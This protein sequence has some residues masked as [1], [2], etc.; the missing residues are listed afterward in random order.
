MRRLLKY[1]GYS[2]FFVIMLAL[3]L[4]LTFPA[5]QVR[6]YAERQ[7]SKQIGGTVRIAKLDLSLTGDITLEGIQIELPMP[8]EKQDSRRGPRGKTSGPGAAGEPA[9]PQDND[10]GAGENETHRENPPMFLLADKLQIDWNPLGIALGKPVNMVINGEIQNGTV[11]NLRIT[12]VEDGWH[13]RVD[14]IQGVNLTPTRLLKRFVGTDIWATLS[15]GKDLDFIWRG[16]VANS[17]GTIALKLTDTLIPHIVF[18]DPKRPSLWAEAFDVGVGDLTLRMTL[19]KHSKSSRRRTN[20]PVEDENRLAIDELKARGHHLLLNMDGGQKHTIRFQRP[21]TGMG[22]VDIKFVFSF[23]KEFFAWKGT[24]VRA[25]GSTVANATHIG[26]KYTL[27]GPQSP[28]ARGRVGKKQT[29]YRYG[30]HCTGM[31]RDLN[32]LPEKPS[33]AILPQMGTGAPI[34]GKRPS[35]GRPSNDNNAT[36]PFK[37]P[38]VRPSPTR[39]TATDRLRN[40]RAKTTGDKGKR[41]SRLV[42]PARP[43]NGVSTGRISR[44]PIPKGADPDLDDLDLVPL[45]PS[46]PSPGDRVL[47]PTAEESDDEE[48][49]EEEEDEL[50]DEEEEEDELDDEEEEEEEEE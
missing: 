31:L 40:G 28:L 35:A 20:A 19:E 8:E 27:E 42:E 49:D 11:S 3:F 41:K 4:L 9:A 43:S 36:K 37:R 14:Q 33:R 23:T 26:L 47:G 1:T 22:L 5:D 10:E 39:P 50:D 2:L 34:S 16:S 48:V 44:K 6:Q 12:Q 45:E 25:D 46:V 38:T 18:R 30:Y 24:G 32:C 21:E 17:E 7:L 13:I 29:G 15:S